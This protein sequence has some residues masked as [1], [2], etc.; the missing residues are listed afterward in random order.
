MDETMAHI[1]FS[2]FEEKAVWYAI[3]QYKVH[4]RGA[5]P[6]ACTMWYG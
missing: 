2:D 6:K 4:S 5:C 1:S 3:L